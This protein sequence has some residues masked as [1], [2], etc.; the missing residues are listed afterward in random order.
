MALGKT[1]MRDRH[2][3]TPH[4]GKNAGVGKQS[5]AMAAGIGALAGFMLAYQGASGEAAFLGSGVVLQMLLPSATCCH[6]R[7]IFAQGD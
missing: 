1:S 7:S 3:L 4:A 2:F 6:R 5:A